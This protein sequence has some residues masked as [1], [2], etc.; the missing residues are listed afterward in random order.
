MPQPSAPVQSHGQDL[1]W[2]TVL[3]AA[4]HYVQVRCLG[5]WGCE[6]T[7]LVLSH[8]SWTSFFTGCSHR[9]LRGRGQSIS[10]LGQR[11]WQ[12]DWD[13]SGLSSCFP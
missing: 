3:C 10:P 5:F 6:L 4:P 8:L 11:A 12:Q 7:P 9:V 2:G 1:C 13:Q